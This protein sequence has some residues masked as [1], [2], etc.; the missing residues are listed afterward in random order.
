V[1]GAL[2]LEATTEGVFTD[3]HV[4]VVS[5]VATSLAVALQ[6]AGL[7]A[8]AQQELAERRAAEAALRASEQSLRE[9]AEDLAARNAELDAFAHTV[10]HDLKAPLALLIGYTTFLEA[11]DGQP[12]DDESL[13]RS[14]Q[15]I[16]DSAR[17]MSDIVDE[18][19][20]LASVRKREEVDVAPLDMQVIVSD[21][22]D[23]LSD[24]IDRRDAAV[25]VPET[26]P[27]AAG[28]G[29][30]VKEVWANYISNAVKYGGDPP[31]IE[32]GATPRLV[33]QDDDDPVEHIRFWVCDDGNG[34]TEEEQARLFIPFE[35]L[36]QA[37]VEGY[38]LGLS[39]VQ[40]IMEKLGGDVGVE[41]EGLP[42]EGS[43]FWF[44]LPKAE[45]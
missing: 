17:K 33:Y 43:C 37:R 27:I 13:H 7:Y 20:L 19:L 4:D 16:E 18:L 2:N 34:L 1:I 23:R 14:I 11:D 39:I 38:G 10:A 40:R 44:E 28:Y 31:R 15:A 26:W 29:P 32:L 3:E 30:W 24:L 8:A 42:G 45:L 36:E 6:N 21:V 25:R 35:R 5:Q 9:K 41:S 22:L 12:L